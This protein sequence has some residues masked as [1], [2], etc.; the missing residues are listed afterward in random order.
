MYAVSMLALGAP[1]HSPVEDTRMATFG[2]PVVHKFDAWKLSM[3]KTYASAAAEAE[4]ISA[5]ESNDRIIATHNA[6]NMSY[7]LGHNEFSDL[8]WEKFQQ[9]Y[10]SEL[11]LNKPRKNAR[12]V[13]LKGIGQPLADSVDWV[14][15]GAVTPIKNQGRCGSCWAFST[16]GSVEGAF[17]IAGNTLT[18]LSEED[19]VQCDTNGDHGCQGG[20][21]DNAFEWISKNGI[22]SEDAYPY[23]SGS[24][25]T[26]TCDTAKSAAA[27][28]TLTGHQDVAQG[29]EDALKSAAN[30]GPVSVAIEADKSAFQLYKSGVLDSDAC[31]QKLDHGVLVV[32]YGTDS[33]VGKDY[34]KVKN[35]WG[36][37]W[38]EQGYI[39]MVQGKNMCGIAQSASYPTGVTKAGPPPPPPPTPPSPPGPPTHSHYGDPKDGCLTDEIEISIQGITGDFCTPKCSLFKACPTD[40]P[41][42]V[43]AQPQCALQDSSTGDKYCALIC[44]PSLPIAN[45]KSA[46]E[47]CGTNASCKAAQAGVGLCTY[48]D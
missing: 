13:H 30:I 19:L 39:R 24:G 40:V 17:Q 14:T 23:T 18:S 27:V 29:D 34:W 43:T 44:S 46:D 5:F 33:S 48:D 42:G 35:S 6:K 9:T 22:A 26:G 2:A 8:T 1:T 16:T 21:M 15:K 28:V 31:G 32:G 20:L 10:M 36:E 25:V 47:Q 3:G 45:Q 41:T 7:T 11:Y 4:A 12:Q 37:T 38:G